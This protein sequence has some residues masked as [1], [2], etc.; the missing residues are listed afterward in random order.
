MRFVIILTYLVP[1]LFT[2]YIQDVLKFKKNN[3]SGAK[4]LITTHK[5]VAYFK[6]KVGPLR[7][8]QV[9]SVC[10]KT[11]CIGGSRQASRETASCNMTPCR[12]FRFSSTSWCGLLFLDNPEHGGSRFYEK[13]VSVLTNTDGFVFHTNAIT[14]TAIRT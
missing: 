13:S 9:S 1:V 10:C 14:T 3:N 11:V 4:R 7:I 5:G 2:F 12:L 6:T 8:G